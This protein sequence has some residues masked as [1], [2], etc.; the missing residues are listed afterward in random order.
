MP[1]TKRVKNYHKDFVKKVLPTGH[2]AW[3]QV[4]ALYK[5][6]SKEKELQDI[7]DVCCYWKEKLCNAFN[8]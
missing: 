7:S 2:F 5:E 4:A 3:E 8:W 6:K 1:Q